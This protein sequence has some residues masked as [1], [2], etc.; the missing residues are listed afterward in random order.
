MR[1]LDVRGHSLPFTRK[2][3]EDDVPL[4][5]HVVAALTVALSRLASKGS[6]AAIEMFVK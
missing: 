1:F 5:V 4:R 6:L 2:P 3:V